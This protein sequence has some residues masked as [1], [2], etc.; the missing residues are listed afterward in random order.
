MARQISQ[1]LIYDKKL[2]GEKLIKEYK[3]VLDIVGTNKDVLEV[4]CHTGYFT[5]VLKNNGC[6]VIGIEINQEA[7]MIA[8]KFTEKIIVGDVEDEKIYTQI[9]RKFDVILFMHIL[10][11]LINPWKVLQEIKQFLKS[12]G[13]IVITIPNIACWCIR[14]ALFFNGKFEYTDTGILDKTHL[15]FF[16][17]ETAKKMF[18]ESGYSIKHWNIVEP[19]ILLGRMRFIPLLQHFTPYWEKFLLKKFPNLSGAVF[20]FIL[21]PSNKK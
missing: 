6:K 2:S 17:L 16:T 5:E 4:G 19:S 7:A 11:H 18:I 14:K 3:L 12:D 9:D 8:E 13:Y 1:K 20:L 21:V 15:R 10:E